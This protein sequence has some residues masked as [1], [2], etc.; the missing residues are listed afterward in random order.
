[1]L[2]ANLW[3]CTHDRAALARI[4]FAAFVRAK[5]LGG[6]TDGNWGRS[7][8]PEGGDPPGR[9]YEQQCK[10]YVAESWLCGRVCVWAFGCGRRGEPVARPAFPPCFLALLFLPAVARP[11]QCEYDSQIEMKK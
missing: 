3:T 6:A 7:M 8:A 2:L 4:A 11:S 1:M 5:G 10:C 9:P